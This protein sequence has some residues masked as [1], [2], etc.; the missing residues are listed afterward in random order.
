MSMKITTFWDVTPCGL[1]GRYLST[2]LRG[3]TSQKIASITTPVIYEVLTII[4]GDYN[5]NFPLACIYLADGTTKEM[6]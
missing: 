1:V 5:F 4:L 6:Y 3:M 2:R